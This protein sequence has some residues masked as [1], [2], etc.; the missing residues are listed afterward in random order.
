MSLSLRLA[1]RYLFGKKSTNAINVITAIAGL[2]VTIGSMALILVLSFFNGFEDLFLDMFNDLNPDLKITPAE[3]KTFEVSSELIFRL[4][5]LSGVKVVSETLEETAFFEYR[6]NRNPG[7]FKGVDQAYAG[8]NRIDTMVRRG[9]YSLGNSGKY[10][11]VLGRQMTLALNVDIDDPYEPIRIYMPRR[12]RTGGPIGPLSGRQP[13]HSRTVIPSATIST[14]EAFENQAVIIDIGLARELLDLPD[15]T[16]SALELK[17][18]SD[19]NNKRIKEEVEELLGPD[20]I[21]ANRYEQEQSLLSLMN[22]EKWIAFAIAGLMMLLIS[23]NLVGALWMIVLEKKRDIAI[24]QSMGMTDRDIH[25][26]FLSLGLLLCMLALTLGCILALIVYR[27]QLRY[28]LF[29][30]PGSAAEPFPIA[31][32]LADLPVIAAVVLVRGYL[33]SVLPARRATKV[34]AIVREE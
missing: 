5:Q 21:V 26:V 25:R 18:G 11:A 3:G 24:L 29:L 15:G 22:I 31:M 33:A 12:R 8:I 7:K 34:E 1:W 4:E 28:E 27:L 10:N 13:I 17:L 14:P 6:G 23:F 2:G 19:R 20:F 32:R 16:V 30:L 9:R